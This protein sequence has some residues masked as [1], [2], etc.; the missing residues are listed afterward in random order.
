LHI[1]FT[2]C[3]KKMIHQYERLLTTYA[4]NILGSYEDARD[5]V[6]DAYLHFM[7]RNNAAIEDTKA[8]LVRSVIN[9]SNN[10]KNRQKRERN[11]YPGE[12]LH[13]N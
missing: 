6:Q 8:Y 2:P 4:Y 12:W 13:A 3:I 7:Q 5:V 1:N 10:K 11:L 9:L